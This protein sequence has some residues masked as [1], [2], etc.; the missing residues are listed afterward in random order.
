MVL[1]CT[2]S[3]GSPS[4]AITVKLWPSNVTCAGHTDANALIILN[5]YLL[6]G[7]IVNTSRG[8]LVMKPVLGSLNC[9]FPL[10]STDSGS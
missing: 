8:V 1:T 9:P 2:G 10:M 3:T 7:V 6:P 5:L 4:V